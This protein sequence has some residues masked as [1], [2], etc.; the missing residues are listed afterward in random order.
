MVN[1]TQQAS[2]MSMNRECSV[3]PCQLSTVGR[4]R[5]NAIQLDECP[6]RADCPP[7]ENKCEEDTNEP[8]DIGMCGCCPEK[9]K[10]MLKQALEEKAN[11]LKSTG[12]GGVEFDL[13]PETVINESNYLSGENG[14]CGKP[15]PEC[16]EDTSAGCTCSGK[17]KR[18]SCPCELFPLPIS[19]TSYGPKEGTRSLSC[20]CCNCKESKLKFCAGV[21]NLGSCTMEVVGPAGGISLIEPNGTYTQAG[22]IQSQVATST[23]EEPPQKEC[24]CDDKKPQP[25]MSGL[26]KWY[27]KNFC[28][29]PCQDPEPEP[30]PEIEPQIVLRRKPDP[31]ICI[32]PTPGIT[33]VPDPELD[34]ETQRR[35]AEMMEERRKFKEKS[36]STHAVSGFRLFKKKAQP[37][38]NQEPPQVELT[39][40]EAVRYYA[41]LNPEIIQDFIPPPIIIR[42]KVE[43][44]EC[45][46]DEKK[47]K[48][49]KKAKKE[50]VVICECPIDAEPL[51]EADQNPVV[52][53]V[54][55]SMLKTEETPDIA[56]DEPQSEPEPPGEG[57]TGGIKLAMP[58]KGSGSRGLQNLYCFEKDKDK[59]KMD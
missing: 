30:E 2:I 31:D 41:S 13:P 15:D 9:L 56:T 1:V 39:M 53:V 59:D 3:A 52:V 47:K 11:N 22:M 36:D 58:G 18:M 54:P 14:D 43:F 29:C 23:D 40:E 49:K 27:T 50:T 38:A 26:S 37:P 21:K 46:C 17:K 48:K 10:Q 28:E 45:K 5:R 25:F 33:I 12:C 55:D 51:S 32:A 42:E 57:P 4:G 16:E 7:A 44:K 34:E 8:P 19:K 24:D 20:Q 6:I 35:N